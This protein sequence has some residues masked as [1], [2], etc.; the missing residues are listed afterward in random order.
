MSSKVGRGSLVRCQK[1][2][3]EATAVP[4]GLYKL[5]YFIYFYS[6]AAYLPV[7]YKFNVKFLRELV[8]SSHNSF[9]S[10]PVKG[11]QQVKVEELV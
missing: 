10:K 9:W 4:N 11:V 2:S 7:S 1:P 5:L 8:I 3:D 6:K